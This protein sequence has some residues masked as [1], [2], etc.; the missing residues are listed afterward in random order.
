MASRAH[1]RLDIYDKR[2]Y[3]PGAGNAKRA[4]WY[5]CNFL[6][7]RSPIPGSA[8]RCRL[9]RIFGA[10]IGDGV[11]IKPR[12]NI[13][14]PWHLVIEDNVWIGEAVWIDNLTSVV[15]ER[16]VCLSQ[17]ALLLTGNHDYTDRR[18]GLMT[19]MIRVNRGAWIGARAIVC[20][21]VAVAEHVVL[22]VGSVLSNSSLPYGI[23][24]GNPAVRVRERT[25]VQ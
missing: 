4:F 20:P 16:D 23:Y 8:L 13:K 15:I 24:R 14:Y 6:L 1:T 25:I 22:A 11:V 9:L 10:R 5:L 12:V 2:G 18:F 21:G 7:M 19:G 17:E 3:R